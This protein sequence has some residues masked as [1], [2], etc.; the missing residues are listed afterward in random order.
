MPTKKYICDCPPSY[1]DE[2]CEESVNAC[3]HN[4]CRSQ[5]TC[6]MLADG[7]F[8]CHCSLGFK[9]HQC[10]I[11]INDCVLNRCENNGTCIDKINDYSCS[12][13]PFF[14]G[15]NRIIIQKEIFFCVF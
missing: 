1:Y 11:N 12:C 15:K 14:T 7:H 9:G 2:H 6:Q 4:P 13:L 10:E 5:G 3:N 8:Q